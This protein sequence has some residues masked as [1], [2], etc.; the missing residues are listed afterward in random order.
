[1]VLSAILSLKYAGVWR[2]QNICI[3]VVGNRDVIDM[4]WIDSP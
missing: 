2:C 1:M 3:A 4:E